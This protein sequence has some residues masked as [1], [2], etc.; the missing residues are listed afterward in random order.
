MELL[1]PNG[2]KVWATYNHPYWGEYAAVTH[3][4]YESGSATYIGCFVESA[5]LKEIIKNVCAIARIKLA[6]YQFPIIKKSGVN[7]KGQK[8]NYIFNYS[9][10]GVTFTY[11]G[12]DGRD[13]ISGNEVKADSYCAIKPWDLMIV[14]ED[15]GHHKT[16]RKHSIA[17]I[18]KSTGKGLSLSNL[19]NL[20]IE[21]IERVEKTG[22]FFSLY[23]KLV[24]SFT[25][26]Q[27]PQWL[28]NGLLIMICE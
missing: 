24:T 4:A 12:Q 21:E 11:D 19:S 3:N 10:N 9:G 22:N 23:S 16:K 6:P 1:R 28:D 18:D 26:G 13:I 2:A 7:S 27:H 15:E 14:V 17:K 8:I 20:R 25:S 5:G